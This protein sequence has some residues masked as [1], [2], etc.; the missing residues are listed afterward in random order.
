MLTVD[1]NV[2]HETSCVINTSC[3][4]VAP[5]FHYCAG[6]CTC[7]GCATGKLRIGCLLI[8]KGCGRNTSQVANQI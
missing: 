4:V 5:P 7:I 3:T 1:F 2:L 6:E 8:N